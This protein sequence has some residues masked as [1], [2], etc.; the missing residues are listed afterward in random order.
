MART[1]LCL[2]LMYALLS[3]AFAQEGQSQA[4]APVT[5]RV[6]AGAR[7]GPLK[8]IWSYFGYDEPNY[9]YMKDGRKLIGELA[10]LSPVPVHI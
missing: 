2:T 10:S 3:P 7:T 8:P 9:T 6:N 4:A 5:I 1:A